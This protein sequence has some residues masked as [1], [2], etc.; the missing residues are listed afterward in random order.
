MIA[1]LSP[2]CDCRFSF[3]HYDFADMNAK[4][5]AN[6]PHVL[7]AEKKYSADWWRIDIRVPSECDAP[8]EEG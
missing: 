5:C 8:A 7:A 4:T 6:F 3:M 2:I 1:S